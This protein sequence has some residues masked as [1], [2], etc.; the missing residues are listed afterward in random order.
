MVA[1]MSLF[2][3]VFSEH[4]SFLCNEVFS[5]DLPTNEV[6]AHQ[7]LKSIHNITCR[8][9]NQAVGLST[10]IQL[11]PSTLWYIYS[12]GPYHMFAVSMGLN[13]LASM[14]QSSLWP[15]YRS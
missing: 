10:V 7:F 13:P 6:P 11:Q 3:V 12:H 1:S 4:F 2:P 15:V 8:S 5:P 9:L 14:V